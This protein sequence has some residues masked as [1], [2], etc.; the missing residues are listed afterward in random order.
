MNETRRWRES[1]DSTSGENEPDIGWRASS[2]SGSQG[3][4][5]EVGNAQGTIAVRDTKNRQDATLV[6]EAQTWSGFLTA[7][8]TGRY[9]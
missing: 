4:C 9:T 5:V 2:Y 3:N 8:K 6:F 1:P 7:L